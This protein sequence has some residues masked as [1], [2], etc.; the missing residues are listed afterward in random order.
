MFFE[1]FFFMKIRQDASFEAQ[2]DRTST[3]FENLGN[4]LVL[5]NRNTVG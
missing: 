2:I 4:R 3:T 5:Q 1:N